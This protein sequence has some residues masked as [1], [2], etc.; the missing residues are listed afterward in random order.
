MLQI[1]E[2]MFN[3][4]QIANR[5][6]FN[7]SQGNTYGHNMYVRKHHKEDQKQMYTI[8]INLVIY[9]KSVS[10]MLLLHIKSIVLINF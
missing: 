4:L 6:I 1:C 9:E 7:M 10:L 8:I 2:R 3:I 5:I